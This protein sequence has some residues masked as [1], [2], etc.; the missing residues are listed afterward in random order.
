MYK[1]TLW[2]S[3]FTL[4]IFIIRLPSLNAILDTDSS[5]NAFFARQMMNGEILYDKYHP[6][7]HLPG[8]YYTFVFAF[9]L[10][11]DSSIAP[12]LLLLF[13]FVASTWLIFRMGCVFFDDYAGILGAIFYV[14]ASSQVTLSGMTFEMEHFANLPLTATLFLYLI[15]LRKNSPAIQFI[16]VGVLGAVCILYKIIFIGPMA[17]IGISIIAEAWLER[18]QPG[19]GKK[20]FLRTISIILGFMIPLVLVGGYF[21]SMGLW[22][23]VVLVFTLGFNY[24][25]DKA[26]LPG[27]MVFPKPFGFPLFMIAM[28]NIALLVFGSIGTYRLIRCAFPMRNSQDLTQFTLVLWIIISFG[29]AGLRGSGFAHYVLV[30]VPPL[31][32]MA[33]FEISTTYQRWQTT[34]PGKRALFGAG[35]MMILVVINFF[36]R[37]YDLYHRYIQ[38]SLGQASQK[39]EYFTYAQDQV[40]VLAVID[41]LKLHS[42]SEDYIYV[43]STNLQAYYYADRLPPMEILWPE[44]V[45]ATGAPQ[46]IFNP[47]TKYIIVDPVKIRPQW[48]TDGLEMKYVLEAIVEEQEIYRRKEP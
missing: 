13:F 48:L 33:G 2:I 37:N 11:G 36:W 22:N 43:W 21:A 32:L 3:F 4:L 23:R 1:K 42:T 18:K 35:V 45:S 47:L 44:Y 8:I 29:L 28:N 46:R 38:Y 10:F 16:W 15:L 41:Y 39:D 6:A 17:A 30:V 24:F 26:L 14:L 40:E 20:I 12:K 5:V 27:G 31:S 25:N 9:K 7:H 19:N 34:A